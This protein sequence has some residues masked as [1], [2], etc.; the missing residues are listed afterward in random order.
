MACF[1]SR[2]LMGFSKTAES[3][4]TNLPQ[5]QERLIIQM[6]NE[7]RLKEVLETDDVSVVMDASLM[8]VSSC[9]GK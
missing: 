5:V 1:T 6:G 3:S 8:C 2:K 9:V 7:F 4:N